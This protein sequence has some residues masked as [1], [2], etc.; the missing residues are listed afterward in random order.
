MKD[1]GRQP[2]GGGEW[3]PNQILLLEPAYVPSS[4]FKA[5]TLNNVMNT[6]TNSVEMIPSKL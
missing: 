3:E 4:I 5:K 2:G 6:P 1:Q